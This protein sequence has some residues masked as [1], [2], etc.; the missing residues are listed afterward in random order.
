MKQNVTTGFLF[1]A[2]YIFLGITKSSRLRHELADSQAKNKGMS[3]D[4]WL[5]S[6]LRIET[7]KAEFFFLKN[8]LVESNNRGRSD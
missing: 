6:V 1:I 5:E 4:V 2:S 3:R 8:L 7:R